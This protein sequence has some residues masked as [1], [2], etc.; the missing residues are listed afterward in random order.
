MATTRPMAP[1]IV[2]VKR[3]NLSIAVGIAHC[4]RYLKRN[5]RQVLR[6]PCCNA[7]LC[8]TQARAPFAS[9]ALKPRRKRGESA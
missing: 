9:T 2:A 1:A 7:F 6:S 5:K 8:G 3:R 4:L